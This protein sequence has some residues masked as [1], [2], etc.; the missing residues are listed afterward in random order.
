MKSEMAREKASLLGRAWEAAARN[1]SMSV[2]LWTSVLLFALIMAAPVYFVARQDFGRSL[3]GSD[4]GRL[5]FLWLGDVIFK[6][7][8]LAP[9]VA[10]WLLVPL[11]LFIL[12]SVFLNGGV[13][14]RLVAG[15]GRTK[16]MDFMADCGRFFGR[17]LRA[18]LLAI[19]VYILVF[20]GL[21]KLVST[22]L[23]A[24][25]EGAGGELS[26]II[27]SNLRVLVALL[28]LSLVQMAFDYVKIHI[29]AAQEK[30]VFTAAARVAAFLR[31]RFF[32]AWILY[33][34]GTAAG[35]ATGA[36]FLAVT[37]ILPGAGPAGFAPGF[38]WAQAFIWSRIWIRIFINATE[39]QLYGRTMAS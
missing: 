10:G 32:K 1:S 31:K 34:V 25:I 27:A 5:G 22:A 38:L 18:F 16:F 11:A 29:V 2:W 21:M 36:L 13:I 24:W 14:G 8:D 12:L 6:Y 30:S 3:S 4:L 39:I 15:G 35:A 37:S 9:A 33:L 7:Q 20:G 23:D 19:P 26:V 28:L 17:F